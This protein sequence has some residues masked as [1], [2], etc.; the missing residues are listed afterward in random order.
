MI[1]SPVGSWVRFYGKLVCGFPELMHEPRLYCPYVL[2]RLRI[3]FR[4]AATQSTT[5]GHRIEQIKVQV[6]LKTAGHRL[7]VSNFG[8]PWNLPD[9]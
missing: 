1:V 8:G 5:K 6:R 9:V 7:I 3:L 4:H 2:G